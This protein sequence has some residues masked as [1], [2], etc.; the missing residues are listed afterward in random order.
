LTAKTVDGGYSLTP[1]HLNPKDESLII[2]S[3]ERRGTIPECL[4]IDS[5]KTLK[6]KIYI[7]EP[8]EKNVDVSYSYQNNSD[9]NKL[10]IKAA[11][12]ELTHIILPTGK[13]VGEPN[14]NWVIDNFKSHRIGTINFQDKGLYEIELVINPENE[15]ELKFQWIWID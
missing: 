2:I 14:Q 7:D 6:W 9:K 8:G 5:Y 12:M 4:E 11:D 3:K 13:T 15:D 1:R 10:I